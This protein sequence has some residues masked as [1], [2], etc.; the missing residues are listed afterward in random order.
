M[1]NE[2]E[3]KYGAI[4][5]TAKYEA[6]KSVTDTVETVK[7]TGTLASNL[8]GY[9]KRDAG[10]AWDSLNE[11]PA[12]KAAIKEKKDAED[13]KVSAEA[14]AAVDAEAARI[15][16]L[17]DSYITH[18]AVILCSYAARE[19]YLV[20]PT[21]HGELIHGIP[22]LNVGD[23][24]PN[25]NVRSFGVCMSPQNPSVQAAA[26]K[27][28]ADIKDKPKTFTEKVMDFFSKPPKVEIGKELV[29]MCA[30]VCKAQIFTDWIDGKKDVLIDG[31]PA[32]LGRCKLQCGYG[33]KI[34]FYT[35][36][37]REE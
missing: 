18:T 28:V 29:E 31:K 3:E 13:A 2:N 26:K 30:G 35:S 36:G 23:S 6:E 9:L 10:N 33:G 32:L 4:L 19:S 14:K 37:Q 11:S 20:V 8:G 15:K 5:G 25:I 7:G 27:I 17:Q 24:K 21:S 1:A 12:E 34:K 16:K 22:Q